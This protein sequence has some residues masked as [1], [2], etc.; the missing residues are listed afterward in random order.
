MKILVTGGTGLVGKAIEKISKQFSYDFIFI[1]KNDCNLMNYDEVNNLF[2]KIKPNYVIHLAAEVGGLFKNMQY[3]VNMLENNLVINYNI[4]KCSHN[5]GVKK[6][7]SCLSTCIFPDK[8]TYPIDESYLHLGPPHYSND[9]YAYSK[10]LL[11]IHSKAYREQYED[12]FI[13]VIPTN[14]FGEYDNYNLQDGHVIP[15]LIHQCFLAKKNN[16]PF[17]VKGTGK[18]LR[19]FIYSEDLAKLIIWSLENYN[20]KEGI[21][22]APDESQ[23]ISIRDVATLIAQFFDYQDNII[24][25]SSFSDGQYKKTVSNSK[26]RK[27][28]PDFQFSDFKE[29]LNESIKWFIENYDIC[30]K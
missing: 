28:L 24:F 14:I 22:L 16:K 18:P 23:E 20:E 9:G 19:Q 13:C 25:D 17:I 21:I 7:V 8:V 1:G 15:S 27:Y 12:N 26:L 30:R 10:R 6:L 11:D 3:K 4:L 5:F 2:N 29:S